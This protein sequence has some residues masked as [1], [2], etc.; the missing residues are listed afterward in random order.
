[1]LICI[2][3]KEEKTKT[4]LN[5][6][7]REVKKTI[8]R[9]LTSTIEETMKECYQSTIGDVHVQSDSITIHVYIHCD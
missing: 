4:E 7:I 8:Y 3:S 2:F 5:K 6:T 9:S 1:M